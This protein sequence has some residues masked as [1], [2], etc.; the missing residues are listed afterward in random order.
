[1]SRFRRSF[2]PLAAIVAAALAVG[3]CGDDDDEGEAARDGQGAKYSSALVLSVGKS[4]ANPYGFSNTEA[5]LEAAKI[6]GEP[7][8]VVELV[9]A[10]QWARTFTNY[11][12]Q[13][14]D[15]VFAG[16]SEFQQAVTQVAPKYPNTTY[17]CVTCA[18]SDDQ[19]DNMVVLRPN[20]SQT[21]YLG[22]VAA[23]L[24]T[25]SNKVGNISGL[26]LPDVVEG[27][28]GF[29][30]GVL[31]VNPNA[32]VKIVYVG[33]FQD[34]SKARAAAEAM[35]GQGIDVIRHE[36]NAAGAGLFDAVKGTDAWAVG[37]FRDEKPAA[38]D[39]VLTSTGPNWKKGYTLVA[40]RFVDKQLTEPAVRLDFTD[41]GIFTAPINP[42]AP[43]AAEIQ[44]KV[45][46]YRE[47]IIN[48]EI[49]VPDEVIK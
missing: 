42:K 48:G 31:E 8:K 40:Q 25:K 34:P 21:T 4:K 7:G 22:G 2:F 11:G 15:V 29:R 30:A 32:S 47:K 9:P 28:F 45:D 13:G 14:V 19:P 27:A 1:V 49:D 33:T 5:Y 24:A 20:F 26:K 43:D 18:P 35:L 36:T 23:G 10:A 12:R 39:N 37:S 46:E 17:I 16:G 3:G 38:P 6:L 41:D 44:Q